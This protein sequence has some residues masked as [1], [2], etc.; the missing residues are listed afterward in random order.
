MESSSFSK[1]NFLPPSFIPSDVNTFSFPSP[2]FYN[3]PVI[4]SWLFSL[5]MNTLVSWPLSFVLPLALHQ[6]YVQ[7]PIISPSHLNSILASLPR[8]LLFP[9][10]NYVSPP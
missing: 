2:K 6:Q 8:T 7:T 4:S 9:P 1:L 5:Q 3:F 10:L